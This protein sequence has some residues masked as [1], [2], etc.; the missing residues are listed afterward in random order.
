MAAI[1]GNKIT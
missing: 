1:A